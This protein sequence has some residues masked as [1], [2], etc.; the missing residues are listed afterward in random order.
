MDRISELHIEVEK[1][2]YPKNFDVDEMYKNSYGVIVNTGKPEE[3]ILSFDPEQRK[4][5]GS[6]QIHN[7][8]EVIVDNADEF[9]IKLRMYVTIDLVKEILSYGEDVEVI[10]PASLK[11]NILNRYKKA[12]KLYP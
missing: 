8:Q 5:L 7:S 3:I 10:S 4:Y 9:R 1:F 6:L 2:E 12:I 11:K